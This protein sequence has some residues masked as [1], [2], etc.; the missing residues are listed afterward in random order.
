MF[1]IVFDR[2]KV[3]TICVTY[4]DKCFPKIIIIIIIIKFFI[5]NM[6]TQ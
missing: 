6:L 2:S 4:S 3:D 1:E 5:C